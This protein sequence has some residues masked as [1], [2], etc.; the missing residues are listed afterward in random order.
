MHTHTPCRVVYDSGGRYFHREEVFEAYPIKSHDD[1]IV[2]EFAGLVTLGFVRQMDEFD[3]VA[4]EDRFEF[5]HNFLPDVLQQRMLGWQRQDLM[6]HV[7]EAREK[8]D[9]IVRRNFR[10]HVKGTSEFSDVLKKGWL[11]VHKR[12]ESKGR[13]WKRRW[14]VIVGHELKL[15]HDNRVS[16]Y[17]SSSVDLRYANIKLE[18]DI[19][20]REIVL[21]IDVK[22]WEKHGAKNAEKRSFFLAPESNSVEEARE[23]EYFAKYSKEQGLDELGE[24]GLEEYLSET[25]SKGSRR[26]RSLADLV[27]GQRSM[28]SQSSAGSVMSRASKQQ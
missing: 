22:H 18:Q 8:R 6:T 15:Y 23:W 1:I 14:L 16:L 11:L 5:V 13:P 10:E 20:G 4:D 26:R 3:G 2:R 27:F 7:S 28:G 9:R 21:R 24:E 12:Q 17:K 19:L 25:E